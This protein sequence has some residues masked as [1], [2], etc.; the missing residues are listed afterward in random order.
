MQIPDAN[1]PAVLEASRL[2]KQLE[3][4]GLSRFE[5]YAIL[6]GLVPNANHQQAY[7]TGFSDGV[8]VGAV[9]MHVS[10]KET[11]E[12]RRAAYE[13]AMKIIFAGRNSK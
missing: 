2:I 7:R 1:D 6:S 3:D 12:G 13:E 9:M 8:S 4:Y 11:P 10:S 5:M